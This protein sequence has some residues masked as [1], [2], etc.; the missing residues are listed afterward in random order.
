M[1]KGATKQKQAHTHAHKQSNTI[2]P[3]ATWVLLG[4]VWIQGRQH[5]FELLAVDEA[6]LVSVELAHRDPGTTT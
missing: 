3:A 2:F 1:T 4:E 6:T 5:C